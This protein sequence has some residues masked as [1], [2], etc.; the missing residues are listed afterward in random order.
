MKAGTLAQICSLLLVCHAVALAGSL[1]PP[2]GPVAPTMKTLQEVE[3][4]TPVQ[5]LPGSGAAI[6]VISA[7]GAYYLT[8]DIM[9]QSGKHGIVVT[10]P[11][12]VT[13]DLRGFAL[14]GV[15]GAVDGVSA[16]GD[17]HIENGF[18]AGWSNGLSVCDNALVRNIR[19]SG[20]TTGAVICRGEVLDCVAQQCVNGFSASGGQLSRCSAISCS[21]SGLVGA[22]GAILS[23]CLAN[24]SGGRGISVSNGSLVTDC[25]V[26]S[27][28]S[29]GLEA[30]TNC[31]VTN[32]S[33]H[34]NSAG[35]FLVTGNGSTID[36]N[37]ST[38]GQIGY[39]VLG[40]RNL[41]TRN[42]SRG[43][44]VGFMVD[45]NNDYAQVVNN[46]GANF[47]QTNAWANFDEMATPTCSDGIMNGNETGVDCGGGTCPPCSNGQGCLTAS[48]CQ[49][50]NCVGGI[51]QPQNFC[52]SAA[53]CPPRPN[54]SASCVANQC[55]YACNTGYADC[56][57][58]AADGCEVN[59][60][61]D[62]NNCNACG[63]S[64]PN[65]PNATRVCVNG[66]C[67]FICNPGFTDCDGNPVNGCEVF[68]SC[69][70]NP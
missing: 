14:R 3:P 27:G 54:A 2:G 38:G 46:P 50:G 52:T 32:T 41:V 24:A 51:C 10:V 19:F 17:L 22:N 1:T 45:P 61:N 37:S 28:G 68:G 63:L 29:W 40:L 53:N 20:C 18:I 44:T 31:R 30:N 9:G 65:R 16:G 70:P 67:G 57:S 64:C 35:G 21:A 33:A 26:M 7:P 15:P 39:R 34:L 13:I 43:N 49:S 60:L 47:V 59:V 58:I 62:V 42:V 36:E 12:G 69:N 48:D 5:S 55:Q 25:T 4:R 6:H 66:A 11:S 23:H 56:N 8:A